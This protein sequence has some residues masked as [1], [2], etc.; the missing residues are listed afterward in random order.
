MLSLL[1]LESAL[2]VF[3]GVDLVALRRKSQALGDLF[4][5]L[6]DERLGAHGFELVSPRDAKI[7]GSQVSLTHPHGYA[8]I[9]AL[10]ARGIIGDF[11]TPDVLRFGLAPLYVRFVDVFNAVAAIAEIMATDEWN[12]PRILSSK[13]VT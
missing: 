12:Q 1:A 2:D 3:D 10:I 5:R 11:R 6:F 7:R 8:V 4:I 9:Q 13:I